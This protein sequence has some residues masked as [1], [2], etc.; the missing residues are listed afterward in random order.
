MAGCS[1]L[2]R[3]HLARGLA[4]IAPVMLGTAAG[5]QERAKIEIV[6]HTPHASLSGVVAMAFSPD[7]TLVISAE[8]PASRHSS[9]GMSRAGG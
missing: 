2:D 9:C 5:A 6:P 4:L 1:M 8:W 7:A 3:W